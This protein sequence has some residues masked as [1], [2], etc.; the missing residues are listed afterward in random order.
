MNA[1]GL[2]CQVEIAA[3]LCEHEYLSPHK[4]A[5]VLGVGHGGTS[6]VAA[7]VDA[8]GFSCT[9]ASSD[10]IPI[11]GNFERTS[12]P[13][14]GDDEATWFEKIIEINSR[15]DS[16]GFK[17]PSIYR[18]PSC[19]VH[20][21]LRNPYYLAVTKD[22]ISVAQR[23]GQAAD[24]SGLPSVLRE[25][26]QHQRQMLDWIYEL[27]SAPL[28]GVSYQRA[29]SQ[30]AEFVDYVIAFLAITVPPTQRT[31]AILRISPTGGYLRNE[32]I[33]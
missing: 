33:P 22:T 14:V 5:V 26:D 32:D 4:T 6:M 25:V 30:S 17:D 10:P 23:R 31:R 29:V 13:N 19:R 1:F 9:D 11:A 20:D 24:V 15:L 2:T 28:L 8:L 27:P 12:R 16:W 18:F 3:V 21:A 7:V